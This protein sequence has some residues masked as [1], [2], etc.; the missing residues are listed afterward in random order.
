MAEPDK[1]SVEARLFCITVH[2]AREEYFSSLRGLAQDNHDTGPIEFIYTRLNETRVVSVDGIQEYTSLGRDIGILQEK[3]DAIVP[4]CGAVTPVWEGFETALNEL[5]VAYLRDKGFD[6]ESSNRA[7]GSMLR[8]RPPVLPTWRLI[9]EHLGIPISET[10]FNR[11][12]SIEG[13]KQEVG[14]VIATRRVLLP[15]GAKI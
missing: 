12:L 5:A 6:S 8:K 13:V 2:A 7:V 1:R 3:P 14:Y 9:H 10:K 11:L 4:F 15:A